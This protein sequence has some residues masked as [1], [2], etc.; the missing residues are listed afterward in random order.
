MHVLLSESWNYFL[1]LF[2]HF[3]LDFWEPLYR[4]SVK[5]ICILPQQLL[6]QFQAGPFKIYKPF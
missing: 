2:S 3:Y 5:G 6:L 1:L 4:R